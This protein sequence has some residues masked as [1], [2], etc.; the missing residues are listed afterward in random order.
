MSDMVKSNFLTERL[1]SLQ[2]DDNRRYRG[3]NQSRLKEKAIAGK[4]NGKEIDLRAPIL[5]DGAIEIITEGSEEALE[6][7]RHSTAHLMAQAIKRLYKNV[8]LG[9]G[10]VIENG[11]YYDVDLKKR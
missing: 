7:M 4:L 10:P 1:R 6:I 5:E 8:K 11:F 2:S 9:V 3:I